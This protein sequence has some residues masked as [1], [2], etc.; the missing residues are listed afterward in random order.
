MAEVTGLSTSTIDREL[1]F[2][3]AWM[4]DRLAQP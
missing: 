3:R 1:R 2:A 4:K